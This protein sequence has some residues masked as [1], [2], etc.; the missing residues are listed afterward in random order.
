MEAAYQEP[1]TLGMAW[2]HREQ[3]AVK[4]PDANGVP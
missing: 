2:R 4:M 1:D 3:A